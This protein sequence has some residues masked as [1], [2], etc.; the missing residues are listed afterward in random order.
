[1]SSSLVNQD[2]F[3]RGLAL[4]DEKMPN[5]PMLIDLNVL[6]MGECDRCI[7]AQIGDSLSEDDID[8]MC[9]GL[10]YFGIGDIS[11]AMERYG[12]DITH[13]AYDTDADRAY[14]ELRQLWVQ[15]INERRSS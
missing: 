12:F 10:R 3:E 1:M 13:L 9:A 2:S 8:G 14:E 5:W 4:L 11:I 15:A 6:D 7:M